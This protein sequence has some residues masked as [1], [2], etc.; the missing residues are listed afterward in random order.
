MNIADLCRREVVTIS[1]SATLHDAAVRMC[2]A[3]V[4][5]LVVV[6]D[7]ETPRVTG[8]VTDRDIVIDAVGRAGDIRDL[9]VQHLVK[10]PPISVNATASLGEAAAIMQRH[11]VRRLLV[12]DE[13]DAAVGFVSAD[14]LIAGM[15]DDLQ[16]MARA[17]RAGISREKSERMVA[18]GTARLTIVGGTASQ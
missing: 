4:G 13:G 9:R 17:L 8:I 11:G 3:H 15:A 10:E 6:E 7:E 1:E 14:D 16:G 5:A 18:R 2:E 12:V